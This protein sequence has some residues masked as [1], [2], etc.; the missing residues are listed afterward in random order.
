M[1]PPRHIVTESRPGN[2]QAEK[3][4]CLTNS[5]LRLRTFDC[6]CNFI[7]SFFVGDSIACSASDRQG[8]NFESSVWRTVSSQLSHH[9]QEVLLAQFSLYVHKGGLKPDSFHFIWRL[10][11]YGCRRNS[12]ILQTNTYHKIYQNELLILLR[13]L[14]LFHCHTASRFI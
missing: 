8:S 9:P 6:M 13:G 10:H 1:P 12:K 14:Q 7:R 3:T 4:K 2:A 5:V 11:K